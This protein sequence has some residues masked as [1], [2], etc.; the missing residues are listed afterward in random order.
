[1]DF[2]KKKKKPE[3][4][5][6]EITALIIKLGVI[7]LVLVGIFIFLITKTTPGRT[8]IVV[9]SKNPLLIS[10]DNNQ[11]TATVISIP[12]STMLNGSYGKGLV[13]AGSL[14]KLDS[15]SNKRGKIIDT[16]IREFLGIPVDGWI[17]ANNQITVDDKD[18]FI[19]L[20]NTEFNFIQ[21]IFPTQKTSL[22]FIKKPR[23]YYNLS[24]MRPDRITFIN[25]SQSN[26][27]SMVTLPDGSTNLEPDL[28]KVD[29]FLNQDFEELTILKEGLSIAVLN[30]SEVPGLATKASRIISNDG[31]KVIQVAESSLKVVDC[32]IYVSQKYKKYYTVQRIKE[33]FHCDVAFEQIEESR[34]DIA[35]VIGNDYHQQII[36]SIN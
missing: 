18:Q 13:L 21:S 22:S 33:T 3:K 6:S 4:K 20:L 26:A 34:A 32:V 10:L 12:G 25:L 11:K 19:N 35:V 24:K 29:S 8:N 5:Q 31:G 30:G 1:M 14:Y 23:F 15:L 36:G 27:L 17:L 9:L 28:V 16:T 2:A 7:V